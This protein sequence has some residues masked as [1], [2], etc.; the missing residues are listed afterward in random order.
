MH[1]FAFQPLFADVF[2]TVLGAIVFILWI[3]GQLLGGR[4]EAKR[5]KNRQR[6]KPQQRP[7]GQAQGAPA[8]GN[9]EAALRSEVEDFLRRAQ[10]K[11]EQEQPARQQQQLPRPESVRPAQSGPAQ[12]QPERQ[13]SAQP[14][15]RPP[16]PQQ[17]TL[18]PASGPKLREEGVAEHVARHLSTQ[19]I[20]EHT[21]TLG[22][23]V[24]TAD[25]RLESHLQ[26]KFDHA[27]GSLQHRDAPPDAESQE[28]DLA[29]EIAAMLANPAGMRQ[30]IVANEI[31]RRP[32]W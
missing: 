6:P 12:P 28:G 29:A 31:L 25:D 16:R 5:N 11:P 3:A 13:R 10:G 27:L 14:P 17:Q 9:K 2:E 1:F 32:E 21:Q 20:A 23:K 30:L 7:I 4:Q 8:P 18:Q 26:Q 19:D 15:R 22:V 24:A